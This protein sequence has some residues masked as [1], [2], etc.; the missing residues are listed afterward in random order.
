MTDQFSI[1][2][3]LVPVKFADPLV[4]AAPGVAAASVACASGPPA[5]FSIPIFPYKVAV[6]VRLSAF[7]S[8]LLNVA[9]RKL[10]CS[11]GYCQVIEH[12]RIFVK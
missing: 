11:F 3:L 10:H 9:L 7:K 8:S 4:T 6:A 2:C 1:F 5:K 12:S